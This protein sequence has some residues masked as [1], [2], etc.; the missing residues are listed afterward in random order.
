M[1]FRRNDFSFSKC[2]FINK[3]KKQ[4][5]VRL[6]RKEELQLQLSVSLAQPGSCIIIR[7]RVRD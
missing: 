4:A 7:E 5:N 6:D 3:K 2:V 1:V